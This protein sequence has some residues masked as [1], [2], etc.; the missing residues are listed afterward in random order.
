MRLDEATLTGLGVAL[1]CGLLI[2]IERERR[3]GSG[4]RRAIAGVRTFTLA[5]LAGAMAEALG[6]PLLVGAGGLLIL[7]L[8][9]IAYLHERRTPDRSDDPG[10]TTELALFVTFL[11]GVTAIERPGLAAGAAVVVAAL[12]SARTRLHRFATDL[13]SAQELRDALLLAGAALVVLPIVPSRPIAWLAG[14]DPRRL[15]GLVVLLMLLQA[16][17]YVAA[18]VL[19]PRLGL[20]L[21]GLASGF[22]SSTATIAAM[23]ARARA[24]PGS[25][26]ACVSGALFSNV[27]TLVQL[28]FV[29]AAVYPPALAVVGPSLGVGAVAAGASALLSLRTR[30][31]SVP[32]AQPS[33]RAFS[34]RDA[35]VF[36]ALL[37][38]ITA[39]VSFATNRYGRAA[40]DIG[41]ALAGF[42]DVHAAAASIFSLAAGGKLSSTDVLPPLLIGFTTNTVSKLVAAWGT[43]GRRYV[44]HVAAGLLVLAAAVWAPWVAGRVSCRSN[45]DARDGPT[46]HGACVRR[47][48]HEES[49]MSK[50]LIRSGSARRNR[51]G[52]TAAGAGGSQPDP[53]G[54]SQRRHAHG[55]VHPA[56]VGRR[57]SRALDACHH[58]L[59]RARGGANRPPLSARRPRNRR[60]RG[61]AGP[62]ARGRAGARRRERADRA[63]TGHR[64]RRRRS[65]RRHRGARGAGPAGA[66]CCVG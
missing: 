14:V 61:R 20:A 38:A 37:S 2:G 19:G 57:L 46:R 11:L 7:L 65:R 33:G 62:D 4:P 60:A 29:A 40:A 47:P 50:S 31:R 27:A 36:A 51:G 32:A 66:S 18:R 63:R 43:G 41:A 16:A 25:L 28:G 44:Q 3:K 21:S 15:W 52:A 58:P 22:V 9:A 49:R 35:M 45:G 53:V 24:E 23:G 1:G 10:V 26:P 48:V 42:V 54:V 39:T 5:S 12:L 34:S 64:A 30:S 59:N 17:G 6:Q 56:S 8:A 13:L 55:S